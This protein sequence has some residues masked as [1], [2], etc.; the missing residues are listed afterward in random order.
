MKKIDQAAVFL[1]AQPGLFRCP[2]CLTPYEAVVGHS[3]RCPNG[4][5]VDL[6]KK[7]TLY[8]MQRAVASEY[9]NAMLAARRRMLQA[10]L[11]RG[12]TDEFV[13]HLPQMSQTILD[14]AV[15]KEHH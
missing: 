9:D 2:V 6:S 12:I 15:V 3:L 8:F 7:G 5:G 13:A 11:F 14:V 10:G 1:A 4:H